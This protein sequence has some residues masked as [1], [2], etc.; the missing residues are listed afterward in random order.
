MKAM[1]ATT[2]TLYETD[3]VAWAD[4]MAALIRAGRL[5]EV[6]LEN[7]AEEIES[8]GKSD[9]RA[10][11]SQLQR[12]MIHLIKQKI[13]PERDGTSW[14]T[15]IADAQSEIFHLTD[16]SPSLFRHLNESLN[17]VYSLAVRQALLETGLKDTELWS[18]C[19]W[20]LDELLQGDPGDLARR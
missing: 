15:S 11:R 8:L 9:R 14:R 19:P 12:M 3:F 1:G 2:K 16:D 10:V 20:T 7:V 6:D 5:D 4:E 13:Q 18:A 17:R